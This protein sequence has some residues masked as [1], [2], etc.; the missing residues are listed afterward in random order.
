MT[1]KGRDIVVRQVAQG[2]ARFT[3]AELC[4]RPHGAEDYLEIARRYHTV[5][6][7]N[8]PRLG[9][10]RRNEVKRLM[11]LIDAL[12]EAKVKVI[13]SAAK[14]PE[15]LYVGRDHAYEFER[16]VSRMNEMQSAAYLER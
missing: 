14:P 11:N 10:D 2:I 9:Y 8:V 1:V 16:A 4:E 15:K 13:F 5:F 12:Y 6:L 3:F 7:E